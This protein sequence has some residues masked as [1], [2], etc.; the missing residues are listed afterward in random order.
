MVL[1]CTSHFECIQL[2]SGIRNMV[3]ALHALSGPKFSN[4]CTNQTCIQKRG[5]VTCKQGN[6]R[7]TLEMH[8][9]YRHCS[10]KRE[11]ESSETYD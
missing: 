5:L 7:L 2:P 11:L 1:R 3:F 9:A 10:A 8:T 6:D 4:I